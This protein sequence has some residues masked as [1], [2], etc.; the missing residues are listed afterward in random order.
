MERNIKGKDGSP[1]SLFASICRHLII[2]FVLM[3]LLINY[4][5]NEYRLYSSVFPIIG[6]RDLQ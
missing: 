2:L 1:G 3:G 6:F 5:I 4:T